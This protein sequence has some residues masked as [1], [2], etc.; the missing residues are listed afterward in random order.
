VNEHELDRLLD[1]RLRAAFAPPPAA[2]FVA[3]AQATAGAR[4]P[5]RVWPFLLAAAAI[6]VTVLVGVFAATGRGPRGPEGHDGQQLGALWVA[7]WEDAAARGFDSMSCCDP[8]LDVQSAC[9]KR[10]GKGLEL[11]RGGS[12]AL[13][14]C[15][16]GSSIGGSVVILTR[17]ARGPACVCVVPGDRDPG[18][19]LPAGS[20]LCLARRELGGLV[21]YALAREPAPAVLDEF[22]M[23]AQ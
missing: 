2:T 23:P 5:R 10:F 4:R 3:A 19:E 17:T 8:S 7:A 6:L 11:A 12:V 13:V 16:C 9:R 14:G 22:V 1:E 20:G 18:V 21:L 15:A